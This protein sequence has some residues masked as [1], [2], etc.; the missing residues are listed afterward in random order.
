MGMVF[1]EQDN[2]EG[3]VVSCSDAVGCT[4]KGL[5]K[6]DYTLTCEKTEDRFT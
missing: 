3:F 4:L 6:G 1:E 2:N 5:E